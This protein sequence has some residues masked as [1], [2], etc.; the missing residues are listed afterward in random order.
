MTV[1][2]ERREHLRAAARVAH[3]LAHVVDVRALAAFHPSLVFHNF[4]QHLS[5]ARDGNNHMRLASFVDSVI[6]AAI[7]LRNNFGTQTHARVRVDK[8]AGM[9]DRNSLLETSRLLAGSDCFDLAIETRHHS[10]PDRQHIVG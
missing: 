4:A 5:V 8:R 10:T 2:I 1:R 7:V 6:A 3:Q 9:V